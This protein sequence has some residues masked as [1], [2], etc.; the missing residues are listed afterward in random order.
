VTDTRTS[1]VPLAPALDALRSGSAGVSSSGQ[2]P[3]SFTVDAGSDGLAAA[4][5]SHA[6]HASHHSHFSSR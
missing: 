3:L 4:H 2:E 1:I 5:R 6:S